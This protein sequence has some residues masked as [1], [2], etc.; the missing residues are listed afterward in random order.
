M[1]RSL[2]FVF[3]I[4]SDYDNEPSAGRSGSANQVKAEHILRDVQ[5]LESQLCNLVSRRINGAEGLQKLAGL[6]YV[7]LHIYNG[8]GNKL[9]L[10][11]NLVLIGWKSLQSLM[12]LQARCAD[13]V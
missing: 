1:N 7:L 6:R 2:S 5:P 4:F 11:S 12:L 9:D 10:N 8:H 13:Q 3:L